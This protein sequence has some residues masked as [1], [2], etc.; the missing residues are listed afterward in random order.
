MRC[1]KTVHGAAYSGDVSFSSAPALT[2]RQR[3]ADRS[4]LG[5]TPEGPDTD[6]QKFLNMFKTVGPAR[7]STGRRLSVGQ[8]PTVVNRETARSLSGPLELNRA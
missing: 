3:T 8:C 5:F 2:Q 1:Y 4:V 6:R 7:R